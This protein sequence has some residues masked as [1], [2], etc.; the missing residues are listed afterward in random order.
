MRSKMTSPYVLIVSGVNCKV[1]HNLTSY[2]NKEGVETANVTAEERL[3]IFMDQVIS[4]RMASGKITIFTLS[5][6]YKALNFV[7][8]K[9]GTHLSEYFSK[10]AKLPNGFDP[11]VLSDKKYCRLCLV[12]ESIANDM[13]WRDNGIRQRIEFVLAKTGVQCPDLPSLIDGVKDA[14][15]SMNKGNIRPDVEAVF[16]SFCRDLEVCIKFGSEGKT[17]VALLMEIMRRNPKTLAI[18]KGNC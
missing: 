8:G 15:Q 18:L 7:S 16:N 11:N 9:M 3:V 12:T 1:I 4:E 6:E 17:S 10:L 5:D 13:M 2:R 14:C